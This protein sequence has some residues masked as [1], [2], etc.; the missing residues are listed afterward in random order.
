M[1][2]L[3]RIS[4]WQLKVDPVITLADRCKVPLFCIELFHIYF[5]FSY[6]SKNCAHIASLMLQK[7]KSKSISMP[8]RIFYLYQ[9]ECRPKGSEA[10]PKGLVRTTSNLDMRPLWG[11]PK[12]CGKC[13]SFNG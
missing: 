6:F 12:V 7:K 8:I 3:Q 5:Y 2:I 1:S 10:L 9:A 11:F 4:R 13:I